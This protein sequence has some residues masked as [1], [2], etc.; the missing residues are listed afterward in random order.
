VDKSNIRKIIFYGDDFWEFYNKQSQ[1]VKDRLNW[2]IRLVSELD[3]I[4][5]KYFKHIIGTELYEIRIIS[6]NNIYRVFCFFDRG[7][8]VVVLNA[9]QKKSQ[10]TPKNQ[11]ERALKLRAEYYEDK[12]K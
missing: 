2:T 1:K 9:F 8:L 6:G 5:E 10:K 3:R 7:N 4:P 12:K 11:I